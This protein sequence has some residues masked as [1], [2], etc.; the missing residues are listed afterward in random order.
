MRTVVQG[1]AVATVDA[2]MTEHADGH[3]VVE[4]GRI[5][6]VGAGSVPAEVLDGADRVVDGR[7]RGVGGCVLTAGH[8]SSEADTAAQYDL[9]RPRVWWET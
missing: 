6:A 3:V 7:V 2:R 1:G 5:V 4:D 9:G 8:G